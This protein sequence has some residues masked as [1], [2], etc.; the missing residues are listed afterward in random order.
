MV[1]QLNKPNLRTMNM[2]FN[3]VETLHSKT[4]ENMSG[5]RVL[6]LHCNEITGEPEYIRHCFTSLSTSCCPLPVSMATM[7]VTY[8]ITG[9]YWLPLPKCFITHIFILLCLVAIATAIMDNNEMWTMM[10]C[11]VL[12]VFIS[13]KIWPFELA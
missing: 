1:P 4:F 13:F 5:L 8:F 9:V 2:S 6:D 11:H 10:W 3:T 12:H 7:Y